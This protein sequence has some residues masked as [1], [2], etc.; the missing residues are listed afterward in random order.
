M[1]NHVAPTPHLDRWVN[2]PYGY[3]TQ[4]TERLAANGLLIERSWMDPCDP[5]DATI[6]LLDSSANASG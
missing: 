2:L 6:R 3:V 5:R 4:V 1:K